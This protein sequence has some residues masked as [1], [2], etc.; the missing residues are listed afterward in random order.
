M[1]K[2]EIQDK[3]IATSNLD[4]KNPALEGNFSNKNIEES[5]KNQQKADMKK[6][7]KMNQ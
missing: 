2:K 3:N 5:I 6:I 4:N 1:T 7:K